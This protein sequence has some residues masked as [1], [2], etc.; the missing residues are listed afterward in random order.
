MHDSPT[1]Y[2][3]S[4]AVQLYYARRIYSLSDSLPL[5]LLVATVRLRFDL[6]IHILAESSPSLDRPSS[7]FLSNSDRCK[8]TS[9]R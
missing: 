6:N 2:L 4:G 1:K 7:G 5:G 3:V 8:S 9:D